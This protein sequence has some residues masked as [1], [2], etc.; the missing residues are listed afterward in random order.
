MNGVAVR[1]SFAQAAS[2]VIGGAAT[3][4]FGAWLAWRG[5]SPAEIGA[6]VSAG[7]LLRVLI[8]PVSGMVADAR[9]DRRAM[10]LLFSASCSLLTR[11]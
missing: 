11:R 8:V 3:P 2:G 7:T 6:I 4:F 1:L 9:N 5:M 10:M